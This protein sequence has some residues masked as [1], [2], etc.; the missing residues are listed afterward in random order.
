V[1]LY[2]IDADT[3]Q[4]ITTITNG[5]AIALPSYVLSLNIDAVP[6]GKVE[7]VKKVRFGYND[8]SSYRT[9]GA[10]PFALC[11]TSLC[12]QM[13]FMNFPVYALHCTV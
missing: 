1:D 4:R 7:S 8:N 12:T 6:A 9:E 10:A 13:Y 3:D 2:L 5:A 11:G